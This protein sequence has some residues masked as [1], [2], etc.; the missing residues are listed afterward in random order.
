MDLNRYIFNIW[1]NP[2]SCTFKWNSNYGYC[3]NVWITSQFLIL[4]INMHRHPTDKFILRLLKIPSKKHWWLYLT[5]P[6]FRFSDP[7]HH[8][9]SA[10]HNFFVWKT[11]RY[12]IS[13]PLN[14]FLKSLGTKL[15]ITSENQ[16]NVQGESLKFLYFLNVT[17]WNQEK[18]YFSPFFQFGLN[19]EM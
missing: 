2:F 16:I 9:F 1:K 18:S 5:F 8:D 13:C 10:I 14:T 4:H 6:L 15:Y 12:Q 7:R 19:E 11:D 17:S 3:I